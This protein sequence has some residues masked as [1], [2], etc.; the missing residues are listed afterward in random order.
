M[1]LTREQAFFLTVLS[2]HLNGQQTAPPDELD[3]RSIAK[4]AKSHQVE[5]IFYHQC[6]DYLARHT[7]LSDVAAKLNA[8]NAAA[9]YYYMNRSAM[10]GQL[11][12][13]LEKE[14]I[15]YFI[16][17]GAEV[18]KLYPVPALRTMGDTDLVVHTEDRER[19]HEMLLQQGW[20]NTSKDPDYEWRYF[21]NRMEI[22][23]HDHLVYEEV[24]TKDEH[25]AYFNAF[26]QYVDGTE[27]DWNFHFLFLLLH[28]RKH[29]MNSG[30]GFRQ[31]MDLAVVI[32]KQYSAMDWTRIEQELDKL[33]MLRFARICFAFCNRWFETNTQI[34]SADLDRDFYKRATEKIF[35]DGVFGFDNA[36]NRDNQVVNSVRQSKQLPLLSM[37]ALAWKKVL[38]SYHELM[39]IDHYAFLKKKPYLLP[40]AWVYRVIRGLLIGRGELGVRKVKKSFTSAG[41]IEKR[42]D[43]LSQW[44]L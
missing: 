19:V 22:E 30:V 39:K 18:A 17:K 34:E 42:S 36:E 25:E 2:D 20:E 43:M 16:V 10:V 3:W 15:P 6:K 40:I 4:Y 1:S 11:T 35:V 13:E 37:I 29:F 21:K 33:D 9:F 27:L 24:V 14:G 12:A 38:P 31:F 32:D 26:W 5:G 23:L 7:E 41:T 44:G 28:L 8:A